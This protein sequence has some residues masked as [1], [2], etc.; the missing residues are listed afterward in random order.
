MDASF[1]LC[2][3]ILY[4]RADQIASFSP[5]FCVQGT[6]TCS[7]QKLV[8]LIDNLS[9]S[10][11]DA[12]QSIAF[13]SLLKYKN[14]QIERSLC[15][16]IADTFDATAQEFSIDGKKVKMTIDEVDQILGL[17][18]IGPEIYDLPKRKVPELFQ[19][20]KWNNDTSIKLASLK[21]DLISTDDYGDDFIRIFLLYT[22]GIYLCPTTQSNVKSDYMALVENVQEI[23]NLNWS[24]LVLNNLMYQIKQCKEKKSQY[25]QG[26]LYLLQVLS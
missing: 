1:N 4:S 20:Y 26:N 3:L 7:Q 11:K 23:H 17:P 10:R 14:L 9:Q 25:L 24:S 21:E 15:K 16:A 13:G 19:K 12:I 22:I 2:F 18:A 6:L 5:L 8:E